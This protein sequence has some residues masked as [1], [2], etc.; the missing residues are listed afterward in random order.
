MRRAAIS[1]LVGLAVVGT[2]ALA[3]SDH[4]TSLAATLKADHQSMVFV[5]NDGTCKRLHHAGSYYLNIQGAL[6]LIPDTTT[7]DN[8]FRDKTV[9][10]LSSTSF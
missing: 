10:E 9:E 6:H 5:S 8:L 2:I 3:S 1:A 4:N 7:F